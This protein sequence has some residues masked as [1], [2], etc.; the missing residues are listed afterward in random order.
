MLEY[1]RKNSQTLQSILLRGSGAVP[2]EDSPREDFKSTRPRRLT[3]AQKRQELEF[4]SRRKEEPRLTEAES[5][6]EASLKQ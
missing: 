4:A 3:W 2:D 5:I 6:F 1:E